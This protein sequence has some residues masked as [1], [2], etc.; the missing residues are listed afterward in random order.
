MFW[1]LEGSRPKSSRAAF[2][3]GFLTLTAITHHLDD[4]MAEVGSGSDEKK[5]GKTMVFPHLTPFDT[6]V[7]VTVLATYSNR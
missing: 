3:R 6:D 4:S 7:T 2:S 5:V 1:T